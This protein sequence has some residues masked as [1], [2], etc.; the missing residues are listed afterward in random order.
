VGTE[1]WENL[2]AILPRAIFPAGADVSGQRRLL[3][4]LTVEWPVVA[5]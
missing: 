5:A 2:D 1:L 4:E 3:S